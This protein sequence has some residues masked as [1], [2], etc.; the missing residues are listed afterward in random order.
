[1]DV[2][3]LQRRLMVLGLDPG[4]LDGK[5]GAKT[6]AAT[7]AALE[8]L[9]GPAVALPQTQ[10]PAIVM[11][12]ASL[13][14]LVAPAAP[15]L[16]EWA[17]AIRDACARF[18]INTIRRVAAFIAQMAHESGMIVG[19]EENLNYS[20]A[21][22]TQVWPSRFPTIA[23]AEP[24]ARNPEKLANKV[25]ANRM[26]N[27]DEASGDGWRFRG[28]GPGQLTGADN[29]HGFAAAMDMSIDQALAFGRDLRGGVMAFAWFW[30]E[31]DLNRLADTPGVN[32]ETRRINGG[33]HGLADR[34]AKFD[35]LVAEMLRRERAA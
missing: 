23:A 27:R 32:D 17:Y 4:P 1:M 9:S 24:Y 5:M 6:L 8:R 21:R 15:R 31:N 29:W 34:K 19:R 28:A 11:V 35:A 18:E 3:T 20:A 26:G 16:D 30:E 14:K 10:T 7:I 2:A 13:L 25:Y 33:E 22:L 12:D